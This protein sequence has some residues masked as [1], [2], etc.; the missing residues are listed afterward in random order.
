ML[1]KSQAAAWHATIGVPGHYSGR[2]ESSQSPECPTLPVPVQR[3]H[4]TLTNIATNL[5][6]QI[7][8]N[9]QESKTNQKCI[10]DNDTDTASANSAALAPHVPNL[11]VIP[12]PACRTIASESM[13]EHPDSTFRGLGGLIV[14]SQPRLAECWRRSFAHHNTGGPCSTGSQN[15]TALGSCVYTEERPAWSV[16][17]VLA[18]PQSSRGKFSSKSTQEF[19]DGVIERSASAS[20]K[21]SS[22]LFW[23]RVTS[24]KATSAHFDQEVVP[25]SARR[26]PMLYDCTMDQARLCCS[27]AVWHPALKSHLHSSLELT[28][29]LE[30]GCPVAGAG[31]KIVNPHYAV[32]AM[33]RTL[34]HKN[35]SVLNFRNSEP[36]RSPS[37]PS[38]VPS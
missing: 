4:A 18:A 11:A 7:T 15:S 37:G 35:S 12:G 27:V 5:T 28:A 25:P 36:G 34:S 19:R 38:Q 6:L 1:D 30:L 20:K 2:L 23:L 26:E 21:P 33:H 32:A 10:Y 16:A 31:I 24:S 14:A 29:R 13:P 17:E 8:D 22:L 9:T 3:S